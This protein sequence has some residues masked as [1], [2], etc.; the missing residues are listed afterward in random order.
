MAVGGYEDFWFV[1]L[2]RN[3]FVMTWIHLCWFAVGLQLVSWFVLV[4]NYLLFD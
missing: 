4:C 1:I 3:D 2:I